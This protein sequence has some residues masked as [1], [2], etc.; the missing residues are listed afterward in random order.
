MFQRILNN[1]KIQ[2]YFSTKKDYYKI[3]GVPKN[4][5]EKTIK[6]SYVKLA[7]QYHPDKNPAPDAKD[8]FSEIS[9]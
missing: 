2:K 9:E 6:K 8:K 5:D 3:L 4:A 7:Q 1:I